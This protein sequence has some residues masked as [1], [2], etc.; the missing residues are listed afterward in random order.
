[1]SG[2]VDCDESIEPQIYHDMDHEYEAGDKEC[3][4]LLSV[5]GRLKNHS[6]FWLQ[7]L[8]PSPFVKEVIIQGYRIPFIRLPD[9][10]FYKNHKSALEHADFVEEAIRKLLAARCIKQCS[11]CPSVCSPLSVVINARGKK[12]LV[13]DLRYVNQ[14]ILMS[15]FKY[16][17]LNVVPQLFSKGDFFITFDLKSGYHHV[18][19]HDDCWSYLGFS[20]GSGPNKKYFMFKVLPFGLASACY[21]FTKLL[22]PLVK[23][24]RS[25]G[26]R[27]I[28]YIDD[29]IC[30]SMTKV[31]CLAAKEILLADLDKAGFILSLEK[32]ALCPVQKGNWLGFIIDLANGS[33][34]VPSDKITRL[35]SRIGSM[36][37][38]SFAYARTL[39]SIVGQIMS[40]SLAIG[41]VAR[42]RTRALYSAINSRQSWSD[43]LLLSDDAKLELSF[44]KECIPMFNG[45]AI[46][47]E[48]GATR[49]AYSDASSS[50]YGGY[51]VEFG[52]DISHGHWSVEESKMSSTWRE[53]RAVFA[54]LQAFV[55]K[56]RG[57][58]I[59][60]FTDNQ[61]VVR[62]VKVGSKKT[63]LQD[64][65][66]CI[67]QTCMRYGI[68][69]EMEWIP[70]RDNEV[71]D[72]LS[73]IVDLDDWQINPNIFRRF[74]TM[75]G[76][77][78]VDR[79]ASVSNTQLARFNSK[80]WSIGSE[81]VDTFTVDWAG[82]VNWWVPPLHMIIRTVR[83]AQ[84]CA[85]KGTL[86]FPVW[87]SAYFW[88]VICPDGRHLAGYIHRWCVMP[89]TAELIIAG[90]SGGSL[91]DALTVNSLFMFVWI[92]CTIPL[93]DFK[94][95][96][97]TYNFSGS[98]PS[99]SLVWPMS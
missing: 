20:W 76:P 52:P 93:R 63:H 45:Q 53:L 91:G 84:A 89:Y 27:C 55:E 34:L 36:N 17:G 65:A 72:Y 49:V 64:G 56:L 46:W 2:I 74:N 57:H 29:G 26:L 67:F 60:W 86:V 97:C 71:A 1:M 66:M 99:C 31:E 54:V 47:F 87:K 33:F 44:W 16:E 23:R 98:C 3:V 37:L 82:E 95:G 62:I 19:I 48:S 7:E 22:R 14:F 43:K 30:A 41:P 77:H 81:A 75:W 12:R 69:L 10:V 51:V 79:F 15:K 40:M 59:K 92:D 5:Q 94:H 50:G 28:V 21:V 4:S 25:M 70:R 9:P 18:D 38:S 6:R 88:P 78:T 39:A 73:R 96:F 42:L 8:E 32:C 35:Q 85:S 61:N 90:S 83:H 80:F 58:T 11:E 68:K 13:L 24:W